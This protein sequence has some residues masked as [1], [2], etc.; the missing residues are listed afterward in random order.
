MVDSDGPITQGMKEVYAEHSKDLAKVLAEYRDVLAELPR[1]N[2]LA[3]SL[4]L[5]TLFVLPEE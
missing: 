4:E 5:P 1:L 3:S 2:R